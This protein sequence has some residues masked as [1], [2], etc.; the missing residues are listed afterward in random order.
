MLNLVIHICEQAVTPPLSSSPALNF[1]EEYECNYVSQ[2]FLHHLALPTSSPFKYAV[3]AV[4]LPSSKS[5]F[6]SLKQASSSLIT[7]AICN[8]LIVTIFLM[9]YTTE[10]RQI[11]L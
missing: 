4:F 2:S 1:H 9:S 5:N 11:S 10:D 3:V 7:H 6:A 8:S